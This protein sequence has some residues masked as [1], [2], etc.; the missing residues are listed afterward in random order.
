MQ[1]VIVAPNEVGEPDW[2]V[3][4]GQIAKALNVLDDS[5]DNIRVAVR[6]RPPNSREQAG[7]E[8]GG[9]CVTIDPAVGAVTVEG[10]P[11][12]SYDVAFPMDCSQLDIF[13]ALGVDLVQ[14]A[15]HGYNASLFAYGQTSSGKSFSMMGVQN[16]ALVGPRARPP[17]IPF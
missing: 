17:D 12:F 1:A 5:S 14:C 2:G 4:S 3:E 13:Q 9:V 11:P 8:G 6:V 7:G 10:T 15:V 16:T